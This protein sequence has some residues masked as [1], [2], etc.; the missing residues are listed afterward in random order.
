[1]AARWY[2][3]PSESMV[4]VGVTGTN[5]K[6]T[7][8]NMIA[9]VLEAAGRKVGFTT[10]VN[11]RIGERTWLNDTKM[12][13]PG[14]FR[15][16]KL[17]RRMVRARCG[18]AVTETSS[19]GIKQHRHAGIHYDVAVFTNLTPEHLE[20][21]GGFGN[22]KNAKLKLFDKL[23]AD[24]AKRIGAA[25]IRKVIVANLADAHAPEFLSRDVGLKIGFFAS[26]ESSGPEPAVGGTEVVRA[27]DIRL[28]ASGSEFSVRGT[29]FSVRMPGLF[30]VENALAAI[31]VGLSQGVSLRV[32]SDTL[33]A[34]KGVPGR[35]EIID[36][37]QD[38]TVMVDYAPEPVSLGKLYEVIDLMP[39]NR[40]IHVLGSCGGG[41]D[42]ARR[43]V[44]GGLAAE[45]ADVVIV[46]NEDPYDDDPMEI[47]RGVAEGAIA[48]GKEE[49]RDLFI[50]PDREE[51]LVK[52]VG[53]ACEGD[54]VI[55]TGKG[56]EQAI[57][58][59]GNRKIPWDERKK[60]RK[61]IRDRIEGK[62]V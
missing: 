44:L 28:T 36:E 20:A 33:S 3:Q 1:M 7:V 58:A 46:T 4:V 15:L 30:S 40:V 32:M 23:A 31:A 35:M 9:A 57:A 16:Q 13:M 26:G 22:Y 45:H 54:V 50:V 2:R 61:A 8:V 18:Y 34:F 25:K 53:I 39:K 62:S 5:G 27:D 51:A 38:F 29:R 14:R 17:L 60:L 56:A 49:G 42:K 12:T 37:G 21:H 41:R 52:A 19:E 55:A 47:M 24:P 11:F 10:T 59:A 48:R 6:S 43:P